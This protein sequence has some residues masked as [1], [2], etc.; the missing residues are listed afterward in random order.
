MRRIMSLTLV[1]L[2]AGGMIFFFAADWDE[3]T[4]L[5]AA[6]VLTTGALLWLYS[7]F[8]GGAPSKWK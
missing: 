5:A 6:V 3:W 4:V 8:T 1:I 7:R 2:G